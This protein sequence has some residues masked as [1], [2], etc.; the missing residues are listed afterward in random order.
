MSNGWRQFVTSADALA[1]LTYSLGMRFLPGTV[2]IAAVQ[3]VNIALHGGDGGGGGGG[4]GGG[5]HGGG[6][7]HGHGSHGHEGF[8]PDTDAGDGGG[9]GKGGWPRLVVVLA[10]CA[11]IAILLYQIH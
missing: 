1:S 8:I 3:G 7:S 11:V 10:I 2:Q 9:G 4:H 5:G 6:G